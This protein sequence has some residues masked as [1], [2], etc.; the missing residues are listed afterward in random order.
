MDPAYGA[1]TPH[2][3]AEIRQQKK[4]EDPQLLGHFLREMQGNAGK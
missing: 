4:G 2:S 1:E 3:E